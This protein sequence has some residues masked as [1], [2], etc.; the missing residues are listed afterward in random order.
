MGGVVFIVPHQ[1]GP[2]KVAL[3]ILEV[4]LWANFV[5]HFTA[6]G[7][8]IA[9]IYASHQEEILEG[10]LVRGFF[11]RIKKKRFKLSPF[12]NPN[13]PISEDGP[14]AWADNLLVADR[15]T[16]ITPNDTELGDFTP[17]E[18]KLLVKPDDISEV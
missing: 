13:A 1:T 5:S 3:I 6:V 18:D 17:L 15:E 4:S 7:A 16:L 12:T 8:A 10:H 2:E 11:G 9:G 14:I